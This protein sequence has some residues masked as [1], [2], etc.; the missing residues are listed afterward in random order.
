MGCTT[1]RYPHPATLTE[2]A[3]V[4]VTYERAESNGTTESVVFHDCGLRLFVVEH[5]TNGN[6][7][8]V[9]TVSPETAYLYTD[10]LESDGFSIRRPA[11]T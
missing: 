3:F 6:R 1:F 11:T 9:L 4:M 7:Q 8:D 5:F 10:E 2:R